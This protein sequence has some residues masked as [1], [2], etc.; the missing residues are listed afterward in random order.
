[1]STD[2]TDPVKAEDAERDFY[3][4]ASWEQRSLLDSVS[5]A[6]YWLAVRTGQM[7]VILLALLIFVSVGGLSVLREPLIGVLAVFSALPALALAWYVWYSNVTTNEP[8]SLLAGTFLLGV[9]TAG[10]AAVLNS[11]LQPFFT[12]LGVIGMVLF[13]YLIVGPVEELV[14]LLA[15][16]LYAYNDDRFAAVIDGAVYGAVARL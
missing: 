5:V 12:T 6:I 16:R 8:I 7:F 10:F 9:L 15:V 3:G 1:M 13:F 4:I 2:G 11:V 14:K